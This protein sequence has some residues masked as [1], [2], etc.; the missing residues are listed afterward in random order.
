MTDNDVIRLFLAELNTQMTALGHTVTILQSYQPT[1]QGTA[2]SAAMYFHKIGDR[3]LGSPRRL[4]EWDALSGAMIDYDTQLME[5]TFQ[6]SALVR[7]PDTLTASDILNDA[8]MVMQSEQFIKTLKA[9]GVGI[10]RIG[11]IRNP[12]FQD[13]RDQF[14]AMPS[15]DFIVSYNRTVNRSSKVITTFV[16]AMNRV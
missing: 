16:T 5:T 15:F 7:Q 10:L 2:S 3:R 4:S 8:A 11:E 6:L 12:Y 9:D 1:K 13:D 14:Q